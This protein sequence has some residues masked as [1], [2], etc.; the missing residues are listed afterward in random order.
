MNDNLRT[1]LEIR[2]FNYVYSSLRLKSLIH[3]SSTMLKSISDKVPSDFFDTISEQL[4]KSQE[5][6]K[7]SS[8]EEKPFDIITENLPSIFLFLIFLLDIE[9]TEIEITKPGFN[10]LNKEL[11]DFN[12]FNDKNIASDFSLNKIK[13]D[14]QAEIENTF[15]MHYLEEKFL[16]IL[17]L[18]RLLLEFELIYL[19]VIIEALMSD[20][21]RIIYQAKP[22]SLKSNNQ[23]THEDII[24]LGNWEKIIGKLIQNKV[25]NLGRLSLNN[26]LDEFEKIGLDNIKSDIDIEFLEKITKIRNLIVHDGGKV[27]QEYYNLY[28]D[29][30]IGNLV[31]IDLE[32]IGKANEQFD[33]IVTNTRK[34]ILK[35]FI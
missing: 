23:I 29:T 9:K 32:I 25:Y 13:I 31:P 28:P 10:I 8:G 15:N 30:K 17:D 3:L 4:E 21:L 1:E 11:V 27:N 34:D 16:K 20:L 19:F 22:E 35:K 2:V 7:K 24:N 12:I 5:I 6:F 14:T 18:E 26:K 33:K